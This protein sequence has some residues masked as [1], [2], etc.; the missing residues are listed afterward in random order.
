MKSI[1]HKQLL[2]FSAVLIMGSLVACGSQGASEQLNIVDSKDDFS[3]ES[4]AL[5]LNS[6]EILEEASEETLVSEQIIETYRL[7]RKTYTE[8]FRTTETIYNEDGMPVVQ[9]T[10]LIDGTLEM[11]VENEY[12]D[13]YNLI[14]ETVI[15]GN[16]TV[17]NT[18]LSEYDVHGNQIKEYNC[19]AQGAKSIVSEWTYDT[20]G[21]LITETAYVRESATQSKKYE[22]NATGKCIKIVYYDE[23]QMATDEF[24]L[25]YDANGNKIRENCFYDGVLEEYQ[26]WEYD[27][28]GNITKSVIYQHDAPVYIIERQYD[29]LGN[30]IW[31][32]IDSDADGTSDIITRFLITYDEANNMLE[33]ICYENDKQEYIESYEYEKVS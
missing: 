17:L 13:Q 5:E 23:T 1:I 24:T 12:D 2:L 33:R 19:D 14:K 32:N 26:T 21:N 8:K 16:G 10:S 30:C 27:T 3:S 20:A 9:K 7:T 6:A 15:G 28:Q 18:I 31:H 29:D 25:E 22:Y 4:E 11:I